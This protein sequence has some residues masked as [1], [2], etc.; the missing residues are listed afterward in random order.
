[1]VRPRRT[2][3]GSAW[4]LVF[5][6][7]GLDE[8]SILRRAALPRSLLQGDGSYISIDE[9]YRLLDAVE[10]ESGDPLMPLRTGELV[11]VELFDPALFAAL[12]S[13]DLNIAAARLGQFKSLVGPFSLDVDIDPTRTR[14]GYRCKYR[15]DVPIARGL[16]ELVFLVAFARRATRHPINPVQVSVQHAPSAVA[17]YEEFFECPI[18]V[19]DTWAV[20]FAAA[21]ARRPF[22]THNSK[23]W[24]AFEPSLRRRMAEN[25]EA[26]CTEDLVEA[27]LFE[28]LPSG[29]ARLGDVA[30][31]IGVG[32]RTL[33]RRLAAEGTSWNELLNRTRER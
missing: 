2:H 4:R 1:M 33:Q 29:R 26:T 21:D 18:T 30:R 31:D 20:A 32:S 13:P 6:D 24:E 5:R 17:R 10:Q 27:A 16:T 22:L 23:M 11:S 9:L 3:V 15:P 25:K 19:D 14:L 7:L 8:V 12:C 28:L